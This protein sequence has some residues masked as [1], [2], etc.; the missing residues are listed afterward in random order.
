MLGCLQFPLIVA[1]ISVA[2]GVAGFYWCVLVQWQWGNARCVH[3]QKDKLMFKQKKY[4]QVV[5]GEY[6][7]LM[8]LT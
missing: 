7:V 6:F 8:V 3:A 1:R 5:K 2:V 4:L